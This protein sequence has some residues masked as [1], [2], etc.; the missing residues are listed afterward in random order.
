MNRILEIL[1]L[2]FLFTSCKTK[3]KREVVDELLVF[4]Y[5]GFCYK[6]SVGNLYP[7]SEIWYN[8][9]VKLEYDST[10]LDI[11][12]YF[13]YKKD[14]FVKIA[15]KR[16]RKTTEYFTV[17]SSDTL[18][19]NVLINKMLVNKRFE[20]TYDYRDTIPMLYDG[21]H[22]TMYFKTSKEESTFVDYNPSFLPDTLRIL[23]EF[24]E[25][26]I[27]KNNLNGTVE[28][29]YNPITTKE[30]KRQF[31]VNHPPPLPDNTKSKNF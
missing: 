25:K 18:G 7:T 17:V 14:S 21:L 16:P 13:E 26:I 5:T 4:G 3:E 15:V 24:I 27:I 8:S 2:L 1:I 19:F 6:D 31:I 30:A 23:H 28:F 22:Y 11:R 20:S 29:K 10:H 12:Q 9:S